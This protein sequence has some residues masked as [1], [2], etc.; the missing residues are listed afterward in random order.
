MQE[1][2]RFVVKVN[3]PPGH[4]KKASCY[5]KIIEM[6]CVQREKMFDLFAGALATAISATAVY[7]KQAA[8]ENDED[9][10]DVAMKTLET[11]TDPNNEIVI[12]SELTAQSRRDL[13]DDMS[14]LSSD[15]SSATHVQ[16][17]LSSDFSD[18]DW[19]YKDPKANISYGNLAGV[20]SVYN[21]PAKRLLVEKTRDP[22]M[23]KASRPFTIGSSL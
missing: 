21:F 17:E 20:L 8:S 10:F 11:V 7:R 9:R 13:R 23:F 6:F 16:F 18:F 22:S 12:P 2:G 3:R 15:K 1:D 5:W 19:V 14:G 4:F